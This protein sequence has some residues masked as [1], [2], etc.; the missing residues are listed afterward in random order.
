VDVADIISQRLLFTQSPL[1]NRPTCHISHIQFHP[2]LSGFNEAEK[3]GYVGNVSMHAVT[4]Q[5]AVQMLTIHSIHMLFRTS[6]RNR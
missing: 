6:N 3:P 1:N 5:I 4:P 2:D